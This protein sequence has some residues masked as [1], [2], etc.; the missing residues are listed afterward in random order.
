MGELL[1][2]TNVRFHSTIQDQGKTEGQFAGISHAHQACAFKGANKAGVSEEAGLHL[3]DMSF[4]VMGTA[5]PPPPHELHA[6]TPRPLHV[7]HPTSES[8]HRVHMHG[9]KPAAASWAIQQHML[10]RLQGMLHTHLHWIT[11]VLNK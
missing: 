11:K 1:P 8:D 3:R 10:D 6:I 4:A 7:A 9:T 5:V 2:K